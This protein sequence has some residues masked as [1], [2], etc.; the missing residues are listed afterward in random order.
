MNGIGPQ[1]HPLQ[2]LHLII[3]KRNQRTDHEGGS[4]QRETGQLIAEGFAG[5]RRHH[6]Q[7]IA[8]GY[9]IEAGRFLVIA[10]ILESEAFLQQLP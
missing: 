1:T 10:K 7:D 4:P 5:T 8:S 3:H 6:E 9:Q 2:S